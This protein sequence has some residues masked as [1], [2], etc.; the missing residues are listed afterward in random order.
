MPLTDVDVEFCGGGMPERTLLRPHCNMLT[1]IGAWTLAGCGVADAPG[2]LD[3]Q[4]QEGEQ[5]AQAWS[6]DSQPTMSIGAEFP[7]PGHFVKVAGM[8]RLSNGT[9]MV[10][11]AGS[12]TMHLLSATGSALQQSGRRGSGPGEFQAMEFVGRCA[13]DSVFVYDPAQ[14]RVSVFSPNGSFVRTMDV[15]R[16]GGGMAPYR[17][18]CGPG[19]HAL[20]QH[21]PA[22]PP[23]GAIGPYTATASITLAPMGR[24][25][26]VL[27]GDFPAGERL[28]Y[29]GGTDTP[30]P[31]GRPT[32]LA[33][34]RQ[35]LYIGSHNAEIEVF[36]L[37]GKKL[38]SFSDS[39]APR[40]LTQPMVARFI[41][42]QVSVRRSDGD[43]ERQRQELAQLT[44]PDFLPP[45]AN[46]LVDDQDRLWVEEY[47]VPGQERARWRVY[48]NQG[49]L[50]AAIAMPPRFV[51]ME[52]GDDYL[53]GVWRSEEGVE[54][55]HKYR[56]IKV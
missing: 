15:S 36:D 17:F 4:L 2:A 30:R 12:H 28:L 27:L 51:L 21:W 18:M 19:A 16:V 41:D 56:V 52:A 40:P 39:V 1:L 37:T 14:I 47:P 43:R 53:L 44:Y 13:G 46:L 20:Y 8:A 25:D 50:V 33:L 7:G 6:I 26:G 38:T 49:A 10:A 32:L 22:V 35:V 45:F 48:S 31:L 42:E 23:S 24:A 29:P 9:V 5:E 11:D 34:G 54:Y 55:V 3:A